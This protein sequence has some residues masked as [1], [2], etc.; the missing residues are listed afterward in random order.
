MRKSVSILILI[1]TLVSAAHTGCCIQSVH[2]R[3]APVENSVP[4]REYK[5]KPQ[6]TVWRKYR[7]QIEASVSKLP[8]LSAPVKILSLLC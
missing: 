5:N 7:L 4:I 2:R 3:H 6:L 8:T 1:N